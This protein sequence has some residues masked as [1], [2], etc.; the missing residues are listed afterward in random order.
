MTRAIAVTTSICIELPQLL[1]CLDVEKRHGE[2][3][4]GEQYHH[5]IL[6]LRVLGSSQIETT[7][8]GQ[9]VRFGCFGAWNLLRRRQRTILRVQERFW[10]AGDL[11]RERIS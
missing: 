3:N 11:S 2:E 1:A 10:A 5:C 8:S 4:Y 6:H 7:A 9:E